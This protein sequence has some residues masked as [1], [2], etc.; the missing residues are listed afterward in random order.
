MVVFGDGGGF[1][2]LYELRINPMV[3]QGYEIHT[4]EIVI[5]SHIVVTDACVHGMASAGVH[6]HNPMVG[7]HVCCKSFMQQP[8]AYV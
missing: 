4:H 3:G 1:V 2:R 8:T 6:I 5:G 7:G